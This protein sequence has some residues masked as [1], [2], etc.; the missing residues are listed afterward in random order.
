M[1][2]RTTVQKGFCLLSTLLL[3]LPVI[4]SCGES[5]QNAETQTAE[6]PTSEPSAVET[7]PEETEE[8]DP[9]AGR[10]YGGR[11]LR[12]STSTNIA[13]VTLGN[14]NLYIE[15]PEELTGDAAPDE[16]F[17][18]NKYVEDLLNIKL[19]F[20]GVDYDYTKVEGYLN[21]YVATA[22]DDFD[23][24]I[25]DMRGTCAA[26]TKGGFRN[27]LNIENF[28]FSAPWWYEDFMQDVSLIPDYQ[29][30]LAGDFFID[31]I[32][33]SHILLVNKALYADLHGEGSD[34]ALYDEVI[35]GKWTYDRFLQLVE[36]CYADLN[37][38]GKPDTEDR[39]GYVSFQNYGPM[40]PFVVSAN[41]GFIE[42]DET[43][44]TGISLYNERALAL[45]DYINRIFMSPTSGTR[46]VFKED[47]EGA[48]MHFTTGKSLILGYQR[49]GSLEYALLRDMEQDFGIL[50][51]PKL[52]EGDEYVTS[53]HD[54]SEIG[55]IPTAVPEESL[56]FI[57]AAVEVLSR[58]TYKKVLPVYYESSM[59]IKYTRDQ[60]S[61]QILD[62]IHDHIGDSFPIAWG[63]AMNDFFLY[64]A[65]YTPMD[66]G[67]DFTS[68]YKSQERPA[69]KMMEKILKAY[70]K[71]A[72]EQSS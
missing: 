72:E 31:I 23:L 21:Q 46:D 3:L 60:T 1:N 22:A 20:T 29:C 61:A 52:T 69:L 17:E 36:D 48:M 67:K 2:K 10:D 35:E 40:I 42:R 16:V 50:P 14:S 28:D 9:F 6:A 56:D 53:A 24:F 12:I 41:P 15:G 11:S 27:R 62:M 39:F 45:F 58:E 47:Q 26:T 66:S 8:P 25:N 5:K 4:V 68:N 33:S 37:G 49:L 30:I 13:A 70:R 43:G 63:P 55:V 18:R 34:A 44:V 38:N 59:K 54:T 32:R 65:F 71:M 64:N 57:S 7:V 19:A 51:Y